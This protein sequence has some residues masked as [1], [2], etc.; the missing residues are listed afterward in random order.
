MTTKAEVLDLAKNAVADRGL[1][2]GSPEDNFNRIARR[3]RVHLVNRFGADVPIDAE[4]VAMMMADVKMARLENMPGH[5]D[6]WVDIAGYAACGG[7]A[8]SSRT[9]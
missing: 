6:S 8:A 1:N 5:L 4:S 2:Y 3:W 7:Q 9:S